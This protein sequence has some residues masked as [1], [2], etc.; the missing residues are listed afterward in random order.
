LTCGRPG[1]HRA[2]ASGS[3]WEGQSSGRHVKRSVRPRG[4]TALSWRV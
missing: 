1:A 3:L 2:G 4:R